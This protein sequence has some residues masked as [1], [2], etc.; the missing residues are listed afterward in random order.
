[1]AI[2]NVEIVKNLEKNKISLTSLAKFL[3]VPSTAVHIIL[4]FELADSEKERI[5]SFISANE[6]E[7]IAYDISSVKKIID[8]SGFKYW[9]I[10]EGFGITDG[11]FSRK[12]R[13]GFTQSEMDK[14]ESTIKELEES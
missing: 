8:K 7:P 10:A 1:M 3:N 6:L 11:Y 2:K 9:Q 5:L 4:H 13:K 14:L 12:L